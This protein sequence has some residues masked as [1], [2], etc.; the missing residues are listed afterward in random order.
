[1]YLQMGRGLSKPD[2]ATRSYLLAAIFSLVTENRT[3]A[4]A[5]RSTQHLLAD[6]QLRLEA[7]FTLNPEQKVRYNLLSYH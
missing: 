7:T 5:H 1:M 3:M 4:A 6:L 2:I